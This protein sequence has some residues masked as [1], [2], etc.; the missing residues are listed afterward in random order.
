[1]PGAWLP[2]RLVLSARVTVLPTVRLGR[3]TVSTSRPESLTAGAATERAV[4]ISVSLVP[5]AKLPRV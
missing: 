1:M 5:A 2:V 4:K 3:T